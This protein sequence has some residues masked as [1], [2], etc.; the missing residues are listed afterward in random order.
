MNPTP[1]IHSSLQAIATTARTE[2]RRNQVNRERGQRIDKRSP[3]ERIEREEAEKNGHREPCETWS[4]QQQP[5]R[6]SRHDVLQS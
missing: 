3:V 1:P 5:G 4:P 2:Q 6:C